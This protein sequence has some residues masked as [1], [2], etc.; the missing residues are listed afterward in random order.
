MRKY[1]TILWSE[2]NSIIVYFYAVVEY[3]SQWGIWICKERI[4]VMQV[5]HRSKPFLSAFALTTL[6]SMELH[7]VYFTRTHE[8]GQSWLPHCI[9]D[10][11][12]FESSKSSCFP[13]VVQ[14]SYLY[15]KINMLVWA[16][17]MLWVW[18]SISRHFCLKSLLWFWPLKSSCVFSMAFHEGKTD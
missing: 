3:E 17:Y 10:N 8:L 5:L 13:L 18:T 12:G 1:Y 6:R 14:T 9:R 11:R 4:C 2:I 7:R 15:A 16:V